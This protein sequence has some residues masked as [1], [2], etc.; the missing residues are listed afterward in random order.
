MT[1]GTPPVLSGVVLPRP[2]AVTDN[3]EQYGS[4]VV[5]ANGDERRYDG[6]SRLVVELTWAKLTEDR[7][8]ELLAAARPAVTTYVHVDGVAYVVLTGDVQRDAIAATDPVRFSASLTLREQ[9]PRR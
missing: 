1:Y 6:G 7:L 3:G 2:T 9:A 4:T 8:V 5:L